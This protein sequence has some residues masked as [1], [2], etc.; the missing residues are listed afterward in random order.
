MHYSW[1]QSI[2]CRRAP[3]LNET[4]SNSASSYLL[5]GSKKSISAHTDKNV[6]SKAYPLEPC[7]TGRLNEL[8]DSCLSTLPISKP[9]SSQPQPALIFWLLWLYCQPSQPEAY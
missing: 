3:I 4:A 2:Y 8:L 5:A 6:Y 7:R 1:Q 9:A